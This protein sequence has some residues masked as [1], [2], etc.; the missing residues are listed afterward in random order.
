M[1]GSWEFSNADRE[2]TCSVTFR[3]ESN[4]VGK[5]VEVVRR[6]TLHKDD[7]KISAITEYFQTLR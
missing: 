3:N 5:R 4:R 1:P 7:V 2:K 6:S